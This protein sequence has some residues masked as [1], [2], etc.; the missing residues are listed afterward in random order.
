MSDTQTAPGGVRLRFADGTAVEC[1]LVRAPGRDR[2]TKKGT[3]AYWAARPVQDVDPALT[4]QIEC[5][6]LPPMTGF[7]VEVGDGGRGLI[8]WAP[9]A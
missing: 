2:Q 4:Y 7:A 9:P 6:V 5:D 3:V 1:E 8:D